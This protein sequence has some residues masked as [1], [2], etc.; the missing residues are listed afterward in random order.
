MQPYYES[1]D[2]G[3]QLGYDAVEHIAQRA[4]DY[5]DYERQR[6]ALTNEARINALHIE[7]SHLAAKEHQIQERLQH[8]VP[9]GHMGHRRFTERYYWTI[10]GVLIAA[11]FFFSLI[12]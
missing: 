3:S 5:S 11:A 12:A 1:N 9:A 8:A 6:I 2:P 10:A 4:E 7:G